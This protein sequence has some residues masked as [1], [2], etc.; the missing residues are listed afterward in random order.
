MHTYIT[1]VWYI[2]A[3][4]CPFSDY[5]GPRHVL[6]SETGRWIDHG[7]DG[8][9][10]ALGRSRHVRATSWSVA[11]LQWSRI[12]EQEMSSASRT[13]TRQF[14]WWPTKLIWYTICLRVP[15]DSDGY[16]HRDDTGREKRFTMCVPVRFCKMFVHQF[17]LYLTPPKYFSQHKFHSV[18]VHYR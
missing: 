4:R 17:G 12:I 6:V 10:L 2:R 13:V 5:S 7:S 15:P 9:T 11:D 18:F 14:Q 3:S 8:T 16:R 1:L